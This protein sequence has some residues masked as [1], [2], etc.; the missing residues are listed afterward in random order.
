M[1]IGANIV[2][3][4][5]VQFHSI[6]VDVPAQVIKTRSSTNGNWVKIYFY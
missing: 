3:V 6:V 4:I 5:D 2:F 1:I